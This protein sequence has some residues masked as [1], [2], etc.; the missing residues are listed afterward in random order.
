MTDCKNCL[1]VA[2]CTRYA[3]TGGMVKKCQ[4]FATDTNV[5]SK[6]IPVAERLPEERESIF[7]K[8]YGTKKWDSLMFRKISNDVLAVVKYKNGERKVKTA[9]TTDGEWYIGNI[10]GAREVTHWMPLPSPPKGEDDG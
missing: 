9:H 8:Y 3:A 10:Y 6:W 7:A 2:V 5:G 1:H 4:H